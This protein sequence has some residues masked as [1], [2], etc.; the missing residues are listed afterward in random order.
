MT[1]T[2]AVTYLAQGDWHRATDEAQTVFHPCTAPISKIQALVVLG[3]VRAR[4]GD[5]DADGPLDEALGLAMPTGEIQRIGPVIA[6][7][8]EAAW[9][10]GMLPNVADEVRPAYEL[11]QKQVD[12]WMQGELAFWLWRCGAALDR[13]AVC[14]EQ[15]LY[16]QSAQPL[17]GVEL[18]REV[19]AWRGRD[20]A[21]HDTKARHGHTAGIA[22][23]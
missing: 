12:T 23:E 3:L 4:R 1:A 5:P 13:A 21:Q 14:D 6:A 18:R 10:K 2:R 9:L 7:R 16:R 17:V 22:G 8:A 15:V 20:R 19:E 11:A